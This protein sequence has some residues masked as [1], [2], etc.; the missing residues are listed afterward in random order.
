MGKVVLDNSMSLDGYITGPNPGPGQGLGEGGMQ[1]FIWMMANP[2]DINSP[3]DNGMLS[4]AWDEVFGQDVLDGT[5]AVIMGKRMFEIIDNPN[6]WVALNGT[7]F[8]WPIF[9]LTHEVREPVR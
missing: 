5:G 7:A 9:V 1:I 4:E 3:H 6:G 2:D 8:P